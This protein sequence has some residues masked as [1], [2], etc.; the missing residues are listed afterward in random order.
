MS[1]KYFQNHLYFDI[2]KIQHRNSL[3]INIIVNTWRGNLTLDID[4]QFHP[5]SSMNN[6]ERAQIKKVQNCSTCSS[7]QPELLLTLV[8]NILKLNNSQ[9]SLVVKTCH[10]LQRSLKYL[11]K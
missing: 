2:D 11:L 10:T 7:L 3:H 9:S 1:D 4:K 6:Q 5:L 8:S